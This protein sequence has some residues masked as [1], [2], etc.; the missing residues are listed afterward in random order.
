MK[1][2]QDRGGDRKKPSAKRKRT[3][4]KGS[5]VGR[6][7]GADAGGERR[8]VESCRGDCD[9]HRKEEQGYPWQKHRKFK[10]SKRWGGPQEGLIKREGKDNND[11]GEILSTTGQR[12]DEGPKGPGV[13]RSD[14]EEERGTESG[15]A[16]G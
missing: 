5:A 1:K 10:P 2:T 3:A 11:R 9:A 6:R 7:E 13:G 16:S 4:V 12:K 8:Q 14:G 15:R